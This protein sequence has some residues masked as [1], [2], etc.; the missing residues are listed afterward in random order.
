[1]VI[2]SWVS[3]GY[4]G[5][6]FFLTGF[7]AY[8]VMTWGLMSWRLRLKSY[9]LALLVA[10]GA[11]GWIDLAFGRMDP[12]SWLGVANIVWFVVTLAIGIRWLRP[13][14]PWAKSKT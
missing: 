13:H 10:E 7:V 3:A 8:V 14:H 9:F 4:M 5:Q 1:M 2:V 6:F 12:I 11:P